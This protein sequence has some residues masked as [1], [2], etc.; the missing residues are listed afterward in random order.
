MKPLSTLEVAKAIGISKSTLERW[1][2]ERKIKVPRSLCVGR[3]IFR[4][5]TSRDIERVKRHKERFYWKGRGRKKK[6]K[7]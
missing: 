4:F 7:A 3:K 5:W 6:P 1:L 2:S